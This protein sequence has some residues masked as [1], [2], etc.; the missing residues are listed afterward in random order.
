MTEIKA[1]ARNFKV[2]HASDWCPGCGDFG[3]LNALH[4]ALGKLRLPPHQV[5]IV[6]GIVLSEFTSN[7]ASATVLAMSC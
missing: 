7:A 6:G 3:I 1:T 2:S 4:Q 5:A